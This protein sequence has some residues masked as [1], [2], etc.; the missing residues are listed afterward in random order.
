MKLTG[1]ATRRESGEFRNNEADGLRFRMRPDPRLVESTRADVCGLRPS[2]IDSLDRRGNILDK[3][4]KFQK[5]P[6][7]L[8]AA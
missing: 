1:V 4:D 6:P 7:N 3:L 2:L 5:L 8:V